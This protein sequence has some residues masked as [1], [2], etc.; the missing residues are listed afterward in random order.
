VKSGAWLSWLERFLHAEEVRGSSPCAAHHF[1]HAAMA[2]RGHTV[3]LGDPESEHYRE[4]PTKKEA[5]LFFRAMLGRYRNGDTIQEPDA[6][7]LLNL[8]ER[9]PNAAQKIASGVKRFFKDHS[10]QGTDCFWLEREIGPPT[11]FSYIDCVSA[12]GKSLLQEFAEACRASVQPD[13]TRRKM[14][15]FKAHGD[16]YGKVACDVTREMVAHYESHLDHKKPKTFQVIVHTFIAANDIDIKPEMLRKPGDGES[17]F[18]FADKYIEDR[19]KSYHTRIADLRIVKDRENRR[20]G[21]SEKVMPPK[22][23]V[24]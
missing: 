3:K 13:L 18:T 24:R 2:G 23:P 16:A 15:H 17:T 1:P 6:T 10:D 7:Y 20:L 14:E 19:F 5:T 4:F 21:G 12:K 9:H 22:R 8:L 11:D